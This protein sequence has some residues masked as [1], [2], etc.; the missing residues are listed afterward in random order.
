MIIEEWL[1]AALGTVLLV[2]LVS[3]AFG[4]RMSR[5]RSSERQRRLFLEGELQSRTI[6]LE[7]VRT[8]MR[9]L[10][11]L[12]AICSCCKSIRDTTGNWKQME[13]YLEFHFQTAFSHA[14]CPECMRVEYPGLFESA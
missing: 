6:E 7:E 11:G 2:V 9:S 12:L 13:D 5:E 4:L 10:Q 3:T 14:V 1:L 8:R